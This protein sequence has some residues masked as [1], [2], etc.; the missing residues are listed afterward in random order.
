MRATIDYLRAAGG[1]VGIDTTF[2]GSNVSASV[3]ESCDKKN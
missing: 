1:L 2:D 3:A